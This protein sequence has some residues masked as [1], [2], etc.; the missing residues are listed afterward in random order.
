LGGLKITTGI[1]E[2]ADMKRLKESKGI[3]ILDDHPVREMVK[4]VQAIALFIVL[5]SWPSPFSVAGSVWLY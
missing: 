2:V 3:N 1:T 4:Q 5:Q